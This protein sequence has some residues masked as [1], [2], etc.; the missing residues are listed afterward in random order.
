MRK[1]LLLSALLL[2]AGCPAAAQVTK[3]VVSSDY[4]LP[5]NVFF[6]T[7]FDSAEF[8]TKVDVTG[9]PGPGIGGGS[10]TVSPLV[11]GRLYAF[12]PGFFFYFAQA[13][14]GV[15]CDGT[16]RTLAIIKNGDPRQVVGA[17]GIS[18]PFLCNEAQSLQVSGMTYL[19]AGEFV[20]LNAW[21]DSGRDMPISARYCA[22]CPS[23]IWITAIRV[24]IGD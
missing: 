4:V 14:F 22:D 2:S 7:R 12:R 10:G 9:I 18:P 5:S 1:T 20:T 8:D 24:V 6:Q 21:Q 11:N 19:Q 3:A 16:R 13:F 23:R 17:A 15:N